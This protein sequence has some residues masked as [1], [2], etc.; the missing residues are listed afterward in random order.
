MTATLTEHTQWEDT[1]GAPL[2]GGFAYYGDQGADP[3]L[4]PKSIFSDRD[5]TVAIANPQVLD[6][7]GRTT[8]KVWIDGPY[9]IEIQ[10][11]NTVQ[12]YQELDNGSTTEAG[13][14]TLD[15]VQGSNTITADAS[16]T[17]TAYVDKQIYILTI[18]LINTAGVTLNID[19]VGAKSVLKNH[20]QAIEASD[21][22]EDQIVIVVFNEADDIFEW[23]NQNVKSLQN[24]DFT[25]NLIAGLITSDG[26]RCRAGELHVE[27]IIYIPADTNRYINIM[28]CICAI[29]S[30][31]PSNKIQGEIGI[32]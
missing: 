21:F 19:S 24:P 29:R 16:E 14:T 13:T 17:I 5:L 28:V 12:V 32:L 2:V 27:R 9:S 23:T 30:D 20:T 26:K 31:K 18:A 3:V 7:N 11:S 22:E 8:N 10:D 6:S 25:L 15:N 1:S 4:N